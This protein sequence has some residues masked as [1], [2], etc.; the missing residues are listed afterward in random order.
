[1]LFKMMTLLLERSV[2]LLVETRAQIPAQFLALFAAFRQR[3]KVQVGLPSVDDRIRRLLEPNAASVALRL[4]TLRALAERGVPIEAGV[5]PLTPGLGDSESELAKL[6]SMLAVCGVKQGS[7]SFLALENAN[8]LRLRSLTYGAWSFL[9]MERRYYTRTTTHCGA[10]GRI[11][12]PG[13]RRKKFRN[14]RAFASSRG[15]VL[16][17]CRCNNPDQPGPHDDGL[18][19]M[20]SA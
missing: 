16:K 11:A 18:P 4:A 19:L 6:C 7:V 2:S 9:E 8:R 1:M 14:L 20:G 10:A 15:I 13:Y 3:V 17:L 12:K 5:G